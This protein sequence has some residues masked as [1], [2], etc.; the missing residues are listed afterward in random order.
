MRKIEDIANYL[1]DMDWGWWPF[2]FLRPAKN[3]EMT[4]GRVFKISLYYGPFTGLLMYL[5]FGI[6]GLI[7]HFPNIRDTIP[8]LLASVII[9]TGLFFIGYLFTFAYFWNQRAK[10]LQRGE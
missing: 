3:V 2:S 1:T 9:G 8:A 4:A 10:R 7:P 6:N 5:I